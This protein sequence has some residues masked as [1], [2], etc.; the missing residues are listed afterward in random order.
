MLPLTTSTPKSHIV[1]PMGVLEISA[2]SSLEITSEAPRLCSKAFSDSFPVTAVTEE[3]SLESSIT[4]IE[5]T[6]PVEPVTIEL[7]DS[8]P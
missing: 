7:E 8:N 5:P 6:P 3:L 4:A 1:L 2:N